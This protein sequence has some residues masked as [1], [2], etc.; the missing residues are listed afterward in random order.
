MIGETR[1]KIEKR[2]VADLGLRI[3]IIRIILAT[4]DPDFNEDNR[5]SSFPWFYEN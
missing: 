5:F 2:V 1:G 4:N 3:K